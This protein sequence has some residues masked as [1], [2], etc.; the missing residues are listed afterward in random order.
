MMPAGQEQRRVTVRVPAPLVSALQHVAE[1]EE[2][3]LSAEIR[4]LMKR[5]VAQA[6]RERKKQEAGSR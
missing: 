6:E 4:V 3:T 1:F 5:R 2:R